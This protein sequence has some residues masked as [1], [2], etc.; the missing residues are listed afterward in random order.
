[1]ENLWWTPNDMSNTWSCEGQVETD[2]GKFYQCDGTR[3]RKIRDRMASCVFAWIFLG[4]PSAI[5]ILY[6]VFN[7]VPYAGG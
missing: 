4:G 6:V 2:G 3:W 5:A 7:K 1:M